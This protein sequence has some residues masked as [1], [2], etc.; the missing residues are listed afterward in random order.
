MTTEGVSAIF[1]AL[2]AA[3]VRFLVVCGLAVVAHGFV[4]FTA[5]VDL[6]LDLSP[7]NA[8][9]AIEALQSLGYRPRAPH[10]AVP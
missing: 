9:R 6:V 10:R 2:A 5:D 3:G 1:R 4:R 7:D 8:R